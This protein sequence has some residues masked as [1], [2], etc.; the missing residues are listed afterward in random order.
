[1][2]QTDRQ[3]QLYRSMP[4]TVGGDIMNNES[5]HLERLYSVRSLVE[6]FPRPNWLSSLLSTLTT[7]HTARASVDSVNV[8]C[9]CACR[10]SGWNRCWSQ[11]TLSLL[12]ASHVLRPSRD[13]CNSPA[14]A[15]T[16]PTVC[17]CVC[18]SCLLRVR[19]CVCPCLC[20]DVC[21]T[22]VIVG[23]AADRINELSWV[24]WANSALTACDWSLNVRHS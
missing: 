23:S 16:S 1:M 10:S 24:E 8:M 3:L 15:V 22:A 19:L 4:P 12:I 20:V 21:V 18:L 7:I 11:C 17:L 13:L 2:E 14:P 9:R 6:T 5:R